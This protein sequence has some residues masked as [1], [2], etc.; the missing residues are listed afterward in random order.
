MRTTMRVALFGLLALV[1][2]SSLLFAKHHDNWRERLRDF[3]V[4]PQPLLETSEDSNES[5]LGVKQ[6]DGTNDDSELERINNGT[7]SAAPGPIEDDAGS[8]RSQPLRKAVVMARLS[9]EVRSYLCWISPQETR[10]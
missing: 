3:R 4:R 1:F 10:C 5:R 9:T 2:I 6:T 7:S 8:D